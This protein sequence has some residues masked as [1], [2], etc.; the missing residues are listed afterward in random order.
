MSIHIGEM[1]LEVLQQEIECDQFYLAKWSPI[2]TKINC[3]YG[4]G[5]EELDSLQRTYYILCGEQKQDFP[6]TIKL[7]FKLFCY[8]CVMMKRRK[9]HWTTKN[10][11]LKRCQKLEKDVDTSW[12]SQSVWTII[13]ILL[14]FLGIWASKHIA[15]YDYSYIPKELIR[16]WSSSNK[17][18]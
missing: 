5:K 10:T 15:Y 2:A 16:W 7:V 3:E 6:L 11:H 14:F 1:S 12:T 17:Y 4:I 18:F 9:K 8:L 13:F